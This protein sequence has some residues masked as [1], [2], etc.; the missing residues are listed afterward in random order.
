MDSVP[1]D[2]VT[3]RGTRRRRSWYRR[4]LRTQRILV[5]VFFGAVIATAC[6]ENAARFFSL[7]LP[8]LN[9]AQMFSDSF[10][11]RGNV[12][13]NLALMAARSS[14]PARSARVS[15]VYPYSIVP[16][17]IRNLDDLRHA[18]ERD[19]VVRSHYARFNYDHAHIVRVA[20]PRV[21]Y[22]SYRIRN[23]VFWTRR[24]TTLRVG[25][26]L[27][28]DGKITAR[29][30]CGNQ[31]SDTAKPEVSDE[32][33]ADDVLND[34]V[35]T[36]E[37]PSLPIRPLLAAADLP[38]SHVSSPDVFAGGFIFPTVTYGVP[39]SSSCPAG[40]TVTDGHCHVKHHPTVVPEPSTLL[41][42][43]SGL[44]L[45]MWRYRIIVRPVAS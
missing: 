40:E 38:A 27:V 17:G 19:P 18:A 20:E 37:A 16:G 45:I 34:P 30:R 39:I 3:K 26:L 35:M 42:S 44:A 43:I 23:S 29:A 41:L 9:S 32:E 36:A 25:E 10:S 6:L 2:S 31:I 21:V 4:R 1:G 24:A 5:A 33:P 8:G 11:R 13:S 14:R 28:T 22:L 15:D 7:S 12:H